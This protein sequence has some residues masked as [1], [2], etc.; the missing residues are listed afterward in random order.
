MKYI[1][2]IG[3]GMAD[4]PI[5][6]MGGST[7]L[8]IAVK[9]NMDRLAAMSEVGLVRTVPIGLPP[10]TDIAVLSILGYN[11][12]E[13]YSGRSPLE[14]AGS[15]VALGDGDI[16]FRC[17]MITVG[18][19]DIYGEK[20]ILSHNGGEIDG[21]SADELLEA[22]INDVEFKRVADEY[23]IVFHKTASF[24]H[25]AV[26]AQG[27][28]NRLTTAPPH[29]HL[30]E[31]L[32]PHLPTGNDL[33]VGLCRLMKRADAVLSA[34]RINK[35]RM[36]NGLQPANGIWFW[37]EGSAVS[38]PSMY[39]MYQKKGLVISAVPLVWGLAN[40]AGLDIAKVPGATGCLD[41]NYEGKAE[42]ALRG[43]A[44]GYDY[45]IVHIEAPDECTHNGDIDGKIE[46]IRRI[47][48]R[49]LEHIL[50][51]ADALEGGYRLLLIS[52]HKTLSSTRGHCGDPVP[53]VIY[54]SRINRQSGKA[55]TEA[56]CA[57]GVMIEDGTEM[58]GRLFETSIYPYNACRTE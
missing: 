30:G 47:D 18:E 35:L 16:C 41:T 58:L 24:R 12:H 42:Y 1:I 28:I 34:H 53:F 32:L 55:Y 13:C 7:P 5:P 4:N 2:L 57:D 37:A 14:A 27:D 31:R 39:D 26:V 56:Q 15:G 8:E 44:D 50:E 20:P 36:E 25:L 45:V 49:C 6:H 33:A 43:L 52:D 17:N 9:P 40:L 51:G 10:G 19:S 46:A 48:A 38:L 3:D 11:P 22:L 23:N 21:A 29:E 54:D